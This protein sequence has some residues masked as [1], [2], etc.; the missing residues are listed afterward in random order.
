[1]AVLQR[2]LSFIWGILL[3]VGKLLYLTARLVMSLFL[4]VLQLVLVIFHAGSST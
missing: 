1:M 2:I 3:A 4:L